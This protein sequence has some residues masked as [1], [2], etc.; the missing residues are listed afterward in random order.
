MEAK[1]F[2]DITRPKKCLILHY[3]G[4]NNSLYPTALRVCQFKL[5]YSKVKPY[6]LGL[7]KYGLHL[8]K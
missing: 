3:N 8:G 2:I 5:K 7:G 6:P 4:S 1:Y